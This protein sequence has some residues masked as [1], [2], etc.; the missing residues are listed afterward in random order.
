MNVGL[1]LRELNQ[2]VKAIESF[3]RALQLDSGYQQ[4]HLYLGETLAAYG[5]APEAVAHYEQYI[6]ALSSNSASTIIDPRQVL[7]AA[8]KLAGVYA[9]TDQLEKAVATYK[10]CAEMAE[11]GGDE[12]VRDFA[13]ARLAEIHAAS[14]MRHS[15]KNHP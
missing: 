12:E 6:E 11:Q 13:M 1:L 14:G 8:I 2:P 3:E 4:A 5:R 15:T 10:K 9:Q 7:N